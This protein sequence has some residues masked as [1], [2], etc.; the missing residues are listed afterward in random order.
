MSETT[1]F[2]ERGVEEFLSGPEIM[3]T[4]TW[5]TTPE[6]LHV[7]LSDLYSGGLHGGKLATVS[8][9]WLPANR[10]MGDGIAEYETLVSGLAEHHDDLGGIERWTTRA[11]AEAGH[12][13]VVEATKD[14]LMAAHTYTEIHVVDRDHKYRTEGTDLV[15]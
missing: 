3:A 7:G 14:R 13:S 12:R 1:R 11:E 6:L 9:V 15:P 2:T 4:F 8:T 10:A 5:E